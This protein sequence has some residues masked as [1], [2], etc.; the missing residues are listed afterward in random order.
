MICSLNCLLKLPKLDSFRHGYSC[1]TNCWNLVYKI[2]YYQMD[3]KKRY[4]HTQLK[5][6]FLCFNLLFSHSGK[7]MH[8]NLI[9]QCFCRQSLSPATAAQMGGLKTVLSSRK[10]VPVRSC[11]CNLISY[12]VLRVDA[13]WQVVLLGYLTEPLAMSACVVQCQPVWVTWLNLLGRSKAVGLWTGLSC[14][15]VQ[16]RPMWCL[17]LWQVVLQLR[18]F[19]C[20]CLN[21]CHICSDL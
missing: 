20:F 14:E 1:N 12:H 10:F 3:Q 17:N 8:S 19:E 2:F 11:A 6:C 15:L 5:V 21:L 9:Y 7:Y 4:F 18:V 16:C 13:F